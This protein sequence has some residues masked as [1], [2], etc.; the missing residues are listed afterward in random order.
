[1]IASRVSTLSENPTCERANARDKLARMRID[2]WSDIACPWCYIGLSRF[3]KALA[4]F[5]HRASLDVHY[6]TF[7]LDPS[8]PERDDRSEVQYLVESKGLP[9][10]Q[11]HQMF[12]TIAAH[13]REEGLDFHMDD[14]VVANSWTAHRLLHLAKE[15]DKQVTDAQKRITPKLKRELLAGHFGTGL[16]LSNHE[17]LVEVAISVGLDEQRVR[18]VLGSDEFHDAAQA[19]VAQARAFGVSAVPTYVLAE[20]YALPGAQSVETFANALQ[21]VW[22]ELNPAPLQSLGADGQ[23]CG[24]DGCDD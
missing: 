19:D 5:P 11:V 8:L 24:I 2:I 10:Q 23:A 9:S 6:R 13:G 3:E 17:Q 15:H 12:E 22:D 18:D 4:D 1:M 16:D 14:V 20:K 7:Q 21:Q